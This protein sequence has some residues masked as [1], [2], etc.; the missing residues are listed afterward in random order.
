MSQSVDRRPELLG[1]DEGEKIYSVAP[2][3]FIE[4]EGLNISN[5]MT[6][7]HV[8][9]EHISRA[10]EENGYEGVRVVYGAYT[11]DGE[12]VGTDIATVVYTREPQPQT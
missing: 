8:S 7:G 3:Q 9:A 5:P 6:I 1:L 11:R 10:I 12:S 4:S 2:R